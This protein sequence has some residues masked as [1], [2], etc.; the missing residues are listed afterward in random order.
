M[1]NAAI[2]KTSLDMLYYSGASQVLRNV[3]GGLGAIFM[4]HHV[5]PGAAGRAGFAPNAGLTI[6]PYFLDS[7][8]NLVKARGYDLVSLEEAAARVRSGRPRPFV[9]FTLDDGYRDNLVHA[10]PVFRKHGCPFTIFAA[11]AITDG[12][13]ELWWLGLEAVIAGASHIEADLGNDRL[14]L[15]TTSD[16]QKQM[17]WQRIYWP[18]RLMDQ[19]LQRQWIRSFCAAN[20]VRLDAICRAEAMTWDELRAIAKEPLCTIGAHTVSHYAVAKLEEGHARRELVDCAD[21]LEQEL[22][23]RPRFLAYPY[24]DAG[25]AAAR[26]FRL[27]AEAGYEAA[28]TTRKGLVFS[29][30]RDHLT[31]LPRLSLSGE[32]QKLRYVEVLL[33]GTAFALWNGF[34]RINVS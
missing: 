31:A 19:K 34:R 4:L 24:G 22:G 23:T 5:R 7:V 27:A 25:S 1:A 33:S 17:A 3:F 18:V 21:R 11:P 6:T 20:G 13:C 30:H 9:A 10:L 26:D 28:V 12:T 14:S 8:I 16:A 2:L 29:G 15:D 32:F